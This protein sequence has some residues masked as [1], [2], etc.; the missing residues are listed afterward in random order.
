VKQRYALSVV[1]AAILTACSGGSHGD[2]VLPSSQ[3]PSSSGAAPSSSSSFAYDTSALKGAT[4]VGAAANLS[5]IS[6]D[7]VPK[8]QNGSGLLRY[9]KSV[10]DPHSGSYRHF[11]TP[12]QIGAQYG[13]SASSYSAAVKY[14]QTAGL[15]V[16]TWPQRLLLHVTGSQT[17]MDAA[18]HTTFGWYRNGSSIFLAPMS[19]PALPSTVGVVGSTNIVMRSSAHTNYVALT[20]GAGNGFQYGY[21]PQEI[22]AG[23]D[24]AGAYA[25]GYT[26]T[27][28]T[29]GVIGTGGF[30]AADV[31]AYKSMFGVGGSGAVTLVSATDANA[32]GNSALG[33]APP[34][35]VTLP[36]VGCPGYLG[37]STSPTA[38]CNPEDIETQLD[39]EQISTLAPGANLRYYLA[40][41]PNDFCGAVGTDCP[42]GAGIPA[43]GLAEADAELQTAIADD[44]ADVLSLSFGG[45]ETLNVGETFNS[46]GN[47]IE[48]LEFAALASEG[49][50]V[51]VSS[52]DAGA[53]GCEPFD[54]N[55]PNPNALC[56]E[57]P[58][59]DPDVVSVG[60]VNAPLNGLGQ[61]IGG[62]TG[63]G[64]HSGGNSG[65]GGGVSSYFPLT[66]YQKGAVGITGSMRNVPDIALD[67]DALTGVA[68]LTYGG[69]Q[70]TK[71]QV[72]QPVG[73]T[74]V[75]APEAAAM[76]ALVLQAC[77]QSSHC[78]T[79][80]GP[81]PYRL[82]NP[83]AYF[84]KIYAN[85]STYASTFYDVLYGSN[86]MNCVPNYA[87]SPPTP[88]PNATDSGYSDGK[89]YDLVTGIGVPFARVL[90]KAVVGQ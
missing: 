85:A 55:A 54:G 68:V 49:I 38:K 77:K 31:P 41:N 46:S 73:G 6:V 82:G 66:A 72:V 23:F 90:I 26:G 30:S 4:L 36:T 12:Q 34:L 51:F 28:I 33:F 56:V 16:A 43:Q 75:A 37:S 18:L 86:A 67:G 58:S 10:T 47:G 52:G 62:L 19:T 1:V 59:T 44:R 11:L 64:M 29:T 42:P 35:P 9:A 21:S 40:Y 27:G 17:K 7:L 74:S 32:P 50:A 53:E 48:P 5:S 84:Y 13:A 20:T 83:N 81:F 15:S 3:P 61:L 25:A 22:A 80:S 69:S 76:W 57:Y 71:D 60:G 65:S 24:Y 8:M 39:T 89:G 45:P 70:F 63:W 14:F 78:A 2:P 88:C 79:A 87:A